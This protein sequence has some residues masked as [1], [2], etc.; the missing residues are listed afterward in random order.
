MKSAA[1]RLPTLL[2]LLPF[3]PALTASA[4]FIGPSTT[5]DPYLIPSSANIRTTS[6]LTVGDSVNSKANGSPYQ[7]FTAAVAQVIAELYQQYLSQIDIDLEIQIMDYP[8]YIGLVYGDMDADERPLL[9]P[10]F[11]SPDYDDAWSQLWPL[12][13]CDAWVSGNAGHGDDEGCGEAAAG[14]TALRRPAILV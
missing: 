12:V 1:F 3:L 5:T 14:A 13:S 8:S 11:W 9:F 4:Q 7:G 2:G 10:S 6:I